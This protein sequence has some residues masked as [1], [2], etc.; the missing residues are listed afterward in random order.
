MLIGLKCSAKHQCHHLMSTLNFLQKSFTERAKIDPKSRI[1][2]A[3]MLGAP[4]PMWLA[5]GLQTQNQRDEVLFTWSSCRGHAVF[6]DPKRPL[7]QSTCEP[8]PSTAYARPMASRRKSHPPHVPKRLLKPI[9]L[10]CRN[11][12]MDW[13]LVYT[14]EEYLWTWLEMNWIHNIYVYIYICI[15]IYIYIHI[16]IHIY[17][18]IYIYI[19]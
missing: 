3:L 9:A 7:C 17:I 8:R 6:L 11:T 15:H 14:M 1:S 4:L 13:L 12:W 10:R 18:Y 2:P 5:S 19:I 16:H